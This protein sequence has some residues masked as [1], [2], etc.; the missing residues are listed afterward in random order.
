YD[1]AAMSF[2]TIKIR[3]NPNCPVCGI[4]AEQVELIDYEQF[5]GVPAHDHAETRYDFEVPVPQI[6]AAALKQRMDAGDD[7]Y[8]LDVRNPEEWEIAVIPNTIKIP[9]SQIE[10]AAYQVASGA[11]ALEQ[12]VLAEIPKDREVIV[13]CRSGVRSMSVIETL[14]DL[15]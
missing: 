13:H 14:R 6:D 3:K 10:L 11:Q 7:L 9:K 8:V 4:P 12:T 2:T 5:C 1:A 15:G